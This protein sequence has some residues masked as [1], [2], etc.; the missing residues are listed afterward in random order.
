VREPRR[1]GAT[2][3]ILARP[4]GTE[5]PEEPDL[6][7]IARPVLLVALVLIAS[8]ARAEN[9][10]VRFTTILGNFDVELCQEVSTLCTGAAPI[11]VANFLAY[12]DAGRYPETGFIH[13]RGQGPPSPSPFVVQGGGYYI[14]DAGGSPIVTQTTTF[15]PIVLEEFV[16]LSNVR[17]SIA[18]ARATAPD[19]ATSQWFINLIDNPNLDSKQD[20][21]VH[22]Y[23]VFGM[24]MGDG[25]EVLDDI[26]ALPIYDL[27]SP[28]S[29]LPLKDYP[30]SGTAALDYLVYVTSVPEPSAA[31]ASAVAI[32]ALAVLTR[33]RA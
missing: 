13:R 9:P 2:A 23:A 21:L 6:R 18:M 28:F 10:V 17:G 26:A 22:G 12:V 33:G 25:M 7:L 20:P 32:A 1:N 4:A 5:A 31:L 15:P 3:I 16:G 30:G 14:D 19:T 8:S 11:S 29:E 27:G 24:V